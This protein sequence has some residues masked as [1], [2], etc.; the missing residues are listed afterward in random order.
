MYFGEKD[1]E[2]ETPSSFNIVEYVLL[3]EG[4]PTPP[5]WGRVFWLLHCKVT[6]NPSFYTVLWKQVT[7]S[8]L[9][10]RNMSSRWLLASVVS[11]KMVAA[12]IIEDP[13]YMICCFLSALKILSWSLSFDKVTCRCGFHWVYPTGVFWASW[14]C[15]LM[16]S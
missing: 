13:L 14:I 12:T 10:S 7:N 9:H 6:F 5:G 15:R 1:Q 3:M 2:G 8:C 11:V 16:F 4:Y